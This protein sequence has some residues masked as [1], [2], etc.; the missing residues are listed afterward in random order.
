MFDRA[1]STYKDGMYAAR[2]T[3]EMISDSGERSLEDHE[4]SLDVTSHVDEE[5]HYS[6]CNHLFEG[7]VLRVQEMERRSA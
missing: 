7:I 2:G 1:T 5:L 4:W 3:I 6:L